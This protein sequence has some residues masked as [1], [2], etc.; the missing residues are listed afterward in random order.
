MALFMVLR[1]SVLAAASVTCLTMVAH[2]QTTI[3]STTGKPA[4]N[5]SGINDAGAPGNQP[6]QRQ[7]TPANGRQTGN[8]ENA[9]AA[10]DLSQQ[11]AS[12][13]VLGNQEEVAIAEIAQKHAEHPEVKKFAAHMVEQHQQAMTKLEQAVPQVAGLTLGTADWQARQQGE[14]AGKAG[15][16]PELELAKA[17]KQQCLVLTQKEMEGKQGAEFDKCYI[18]QQ[19]GAHVGMLAQLQGSKSFANPQLQAVI[20]EGEQMATKHLEEAK[21]I[22]A[23]LEGAKGQPARTSQR[24]APAAN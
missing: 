13:L 9:Q 3:D 18:G 20:V 24:T 5:Q 14:A 10:G 22:M 19:I 11:I 12:C 21:K 17:I 4:V 7:A 6:G 1:K 15:D 2:A 16:S 8:A 23:E